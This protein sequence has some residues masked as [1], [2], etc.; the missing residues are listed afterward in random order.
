MKPY[1]NIEQISVIFDMETKFIIPIFV[2][3]IRAV[4]SDVSKFPLCPVDGYMVA[5]F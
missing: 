2:I 4:L 1:E 3:L 5:L